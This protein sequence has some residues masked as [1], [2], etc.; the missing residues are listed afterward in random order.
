[1]GANGHRL[2]GGKHARHAAALLRLGC[3]P[4]NG[5][6][7][8]AA[9]VILVGAFIPSW[10][11]GQKMAAEAAALAELQ[12]GHSQEFDC[13]HTPSTPSG[14]NKSDG[15]PAKQK[16]CPLC[17]ALQLLSPGLTQP[18]VVLLPRASHAVAAFVPDRAELK[19]GRETAGEARPRAPPLA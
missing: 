7:L 2:T 10:H 13:H 19:L 9:L 3:S 8:F 11:A 5:V 14:Q 1:M 16:P 6:I 12:T 18:G 17:L 15:A 4:G